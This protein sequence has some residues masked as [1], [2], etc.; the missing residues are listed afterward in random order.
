MFQSES[1][2]GNLSS[3][4]CCALWHF[5]EHPNMNA[6]ILKMKKACLVGIW[7]DGTWLQLLAKYWKKISRQLLTKWQTGVCQ[8]SKVVKK[9]F[10]YFMET[11][12][13]LTYCCFSIN[14]VLG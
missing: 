13:A 7:G 11:Q 1:S 10:L 2:V 8:F 3:E 6:N 4:N 12:E 14:P 9:Y 5:H